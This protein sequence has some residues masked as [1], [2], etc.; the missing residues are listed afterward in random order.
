MRETAR[1]VE[2]AGRKADVARGDIP[3]RSED[4][5]L[6]GLLLHAIPG[7]NIAVSFDHR[8]ERDQRR[9]ASAASFAKGIC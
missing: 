3:C 8:V 1:W 2:E 7:Q 4:E 6:V 5:E 9:I